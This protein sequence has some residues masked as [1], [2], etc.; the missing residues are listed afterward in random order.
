MKHVSKIRP[1]TTICSWMVVAILVVCMLTLFVIQDNVVLAETSSNVSVMSNNDE[2][3]AINEENNNVIL[4]DSAR[5][6]YYSYYCKDNTGYK[7]HGNEALSPHKKDV[8][9]TRNYGLWRSS[10]NTYDEIVPS[11]CYVQPRGTSEAKIYN[12]RI[13]CITIDENINNTN[14]GKLRFIIRDLPYPLSHD[15]YKKD[16][17]GIAN[18]QEL[19][20]GAVFYRFIN[21]TN[22]VGTTGNWVKLRNIFANSNEFQLPITINKECELEIKLFIEMKQSIF[23]SHNVRTDY[24]IRFI[25]KFEETGLTIKDANDDNKIFGTTQMVYEKIPVYANKDFK[26]D[27]VGQGFLRDIKV[28]YNG[29]SQTNVNISK[30][31]ETTYSN[32]GTY[33]FNYKYGYFDG[34]TLED[35][36]KEQTVY[37]DKEKT[38]FKINGVLCNPNT[39]PYFKDGKMA[40]SSREDQVLT[41]ERRETQAPFKIIVDGE[42]VAQNYLLKRGAHEIKIQ[43]DGGTWKKTE[44]YNIIVDEFIPNFSHNTLLNNSVYADRANRFSTKMYV[45]QMPGDIARGYAQLKDAQEYALTMEYMS[46]VQV[47]SNGEYE[48]KGEI[49][50]DN[51]SLTSALN[52]EIEKYITKNRDLTINEDME[53]DASLRTDKLY[54]NNYKFTNGNNSIYAT[55]INLILA[56]NINDELNEKYKAYLRDPSYSKNI[57]LEYGELAS[58]VLTESGKYFIRETSVFGDEYFYEAFYVAK[59]ETQVEIAYLDNNQIEQKITMLENGTRLETQG[60]SISN[61]TNVFDEYATVIVRNITTNKKSIY[62]VGEV[63]K[64]IGTPGQYEIICIDRNNN[65]IEIEIIVTGERAF[66]LEGVM[67]SGTANNDVTVMLDENFVVVYSAIN[68]EIIQ[69][70]FVYNEE[71]GYVEYT[72][73]QTEEFQEIV[74]L[75]NYAGEDVIIAFK[76]EVAK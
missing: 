39:Y 49:Y 67:N 48:Y 30:L 28:N 70:D 61:I 22:G 19:G 32:P 59:N 51:A 62:V 63:S 7:E 65:S 36:R 52:K 42:E 44:T 46:N 56:E 68:G 73:E 60:F 25:N 75:G 5:S 34:I 64:F 55:T 33:V 69:L 41:W 27:N 11:N 26:I 37:L 12:N 53:I 17:D 23:T 18:D 74:I 45:V 9:F 24:K 71:T 13:N 50:V 43:H 66:Y 16:V 40:F 21:Y 54:L 58:S 3:N 8:N 35:Y 15:T 20:K 76:I 72:F 1:L 29:K 14:F 10:T 31:S 2:V 6:A 57:K 4:R 38:Y 47:L